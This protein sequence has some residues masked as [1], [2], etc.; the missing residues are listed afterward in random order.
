MSSFA[1]SLLDTRSIEHAEDLRRMLEGS[2]LRKHELK[3]HG[4]QHVEFEMK[5][6]SSF[7]H[8]P[9][10]RQC[11]EAVWINK[12]EPDKRINSKTEYHQPGDIEAVFEK[13]ENL[14]TKMRKSQKTQGENVT[15][16]EKER[17]E[18]ETVVEVTDTQRRI[19]EFITNMQ[20]N[21]N[22]Q[23]QVP[24]EAENETVSSYYDEETTTLSTQVMIEDARERRAGGSIFLQCDN[25]EYK[26]SSNYILQEHKRVLHKANETESMDKEANNSP[27]VTMRER[28]QCDE[29]QF[30]STAKDVLEKHKKINHK[31]KSAKITTKKRINCKQ[32]HKYFYLDKTFKAHMQQVHGEQCED[33]DTTFERDNTLRKHRETIH[34]RNNILCLSLQT[35][36]GEVPD[37]S[38]GSI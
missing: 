29:C 7:Q 28:F 8:D 13:S 3:K 5:V 35:K 30:K 9:L 18:E 31:Q 20:I 21:V 17:I 27:T 37:R 16:I 11:A 12:I 34:G 22:P 24:P 14:I 36:Q 2:V 15:N 23:A 26:T 32:C 38:R 4:G 6:L 10:A 1:P 19:T 25:C 33:C